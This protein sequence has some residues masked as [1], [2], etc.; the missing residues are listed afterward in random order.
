MNEKSTPKI[1]VN[2]LGEFLTANH[3]RQRKI[4][5]SFKYPNDNRFTYTYYSDA[6]RA[7]IA[8]F[9]SK[10]NHDILEKCIGF[11]HG[12]E[13]SNDFQEIE[14]SSSIEALE[15]VLNTDSIDESFEYSLYDNINNTLIIEG[16]EIIVNPEI[17]I[18]KPNSKGESKFG[19]GKI[20]IS[21][22]T[23]LSMETSKYIAAILYLYAEK[24]IQY[25]NETLD[26]K[27]C[28]SYDIFRD[29]IISCPNGV[30][31]IT[32]DVVAGCKNINAIWDSI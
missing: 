20:H 3:H 22:N 6:R 25:E 4:L 8:Y 30:K 26:N 19:I 2:K 12:K 29:N 14:I 13:K 11:L 10:F 15:L 5:E 1:S 28:L 9:Q 23:E 21:K 27:L 7:I 17:L 24:N 31:R 32:N 18:R 16:V